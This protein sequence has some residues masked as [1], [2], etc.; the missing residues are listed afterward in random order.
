MCADWRPANR[1]ATAG[2]RRRERPALPAFVLALERGLSRA[3]RPEPQGPAVRDRAGAPGARRRRA[4]QVRVPRSQSAAA[5]AGAAARPPHAAAVDGDPG[6]SRRDVAGAAAA[7]GDRTRPRA[8]ARA[9]AGDRLRHPSAQQP[10]RAAVFR[11]R[12]A[13]CRSPSATTGS[14]TGSCEGFDALRGAA[15]A[16]T[17]RPANT[18]T[19]TRRRSPTAA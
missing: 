6:I 15:A 8:G 13:A 12:L 17:R 10:A 18:A 3:H 16:T 14:G 4:A 1:G 9:G 2:E 19:A 5:G 11:A 7:A